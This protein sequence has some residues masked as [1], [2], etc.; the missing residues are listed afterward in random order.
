MNV[1][2]SLF[3]LV[4][5]AGAICCFA[6]T[7]REVRHR[8]LTSWRL[9]APVLAAAACALVFF[10]LKVGTGQPPWT[11]GAALAAGLAVGAARGFTLKLQADH[12]SGMI[13]LPSARGSLLVA[14]FMVGAVLIEMGGAF[15]GVAGTDFRL[16]APDVAALCA[17]ILAGRV[18]A[19]A[20]RWHRE[21][22]VDLR[23]M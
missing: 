12:V 4:L 23:R 22:H 17:G 21:P 19:I 11:F 6:L 9:V 18:M 13:R 2:P 20:I 3:H 5:L 1:G 7:L 14:F 8:P 15:A 10:L 16:V